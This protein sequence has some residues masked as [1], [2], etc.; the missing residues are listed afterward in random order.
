MSYELGVAGG[1][2]R[3]SV[4]FDSWTLDPKFGCTANVPSVV[5]E[6]YV[7]SDVA[8]KA[9]TRSFVLTEAYTKRIEKS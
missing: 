8:N 1:A 9:K 3:G 4:T 5:L 2:V 7:S 6:L